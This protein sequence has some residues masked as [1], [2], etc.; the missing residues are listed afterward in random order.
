MLIQFI[1]PAD[2]Y[3]T[4]ELAGFQ[5]LHLGHKTLVRQICSGDDSEEFELVRAHARGTNARKTAWN[6]QPCQFT[7]QMYPVTLV[8]THRLPQP[9]ESTASGPA[10]HL[11]SE[12]IHHMLNAWTFLTHPWYVVLMCTCYEEVL[13]F[14]IMRAEALVACSITQILSP[15]QTTAPLCFPCFVLLW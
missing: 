5:W 7:V 10:K 1:C 14:D 12:S 3:S 4:Q 6:Q 9:L 15:A 11:K 8:P 2:L 13:T